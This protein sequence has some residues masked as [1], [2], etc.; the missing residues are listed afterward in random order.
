[1]FAEDP[2]DEVPI[3]GAVAVARDALARLEADIELYRAKI[4]LMGDML[5]RI[6]KSLEKPYSFIELLELH[7]VVSDFNQEHGNF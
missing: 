4:E 1:M 6:Q 7:Q 3:P 2:T 5:R